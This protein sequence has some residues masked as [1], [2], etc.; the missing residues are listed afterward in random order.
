MKIYFCTEGSFPFSIKISVM[1]PTPAL[2]PAA[3]ESNTDWAISILSPAAK[4]P[5]TEVAPKS[6]TSYSPN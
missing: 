4:T 1:T 3:Q 6:L 2:T 5:G